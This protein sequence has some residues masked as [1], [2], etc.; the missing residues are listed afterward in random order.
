MVTLI[1]RHYYRIQ[2]MAVYPSPAKIN[3]HLEV[4]PKG[5]DG[6][7]SIRTVMAKLKLADIV[8]IRHS[9]VVSR[10]SRPCWRIDEHF[11]FR[12]KFSKGFPKTCQQELLK[13][14]LE[15]LVVRAYQL[16]KDKGFRLKKPVQLTLVKKIPVGAGLGGGSSNAA[17]A[18][19]ALAREMMPRP[20][21]GDLEKMAAQLGSDVSFFLNPSVLAWVTGKGERL[22]PLSGLK[23]KIPLLIIYPNFGV[24]TKKAYSLVSGGSLSLTEKQVLDKLYKSGPKVGLMVFNSFEDPVLRLHPLLSRIDALLGRLGSLSRGLAGSGSCVW[25]QA[26]SQAQVESWQREFKN[27]KE[28]KNY[29]YYATEINA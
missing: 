16:L 11:A 14:P 23:R 1:S 15:N 10:Q 2:R 4:G 7:H 18:L 21:V 12:L 27:N 29:A 6:Y 13:K 22:K 9:L 28:F 8:K 20:R 26:K 24:S 17:I 25:A 3:L 5:K 19:K